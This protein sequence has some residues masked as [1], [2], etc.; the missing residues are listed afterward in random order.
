MKTRLFTTLTALTLSAFAGTSAFAE[1]SGVTLEWQQPGYVMDVVVVT[2]PR[3]ATIAQDVAIAQD[4]AQSV[5][6]EAT[7]AWQE[8]GYVQEVVIVTAS[9]SEM[10][11]QA[12]ADA[13]EAAIARQKA[14]RGTAW[15]NALG[16][17]AH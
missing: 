1:E 15:R 7:P 8:A 13:I 14:V 6:D 4:E 10:L 5:T 9:R 11:A 2:A 17:P 3:P 12:R 16:T